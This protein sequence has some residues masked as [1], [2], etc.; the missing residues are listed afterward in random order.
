MNRF[1]SSCCPRRWAGLLVIAGLAAGLA[2]VATPVRAA[3]ADGGA[4]TLAGVTFTGTDGFVHSTCGETGG[5]GSASYEVEGRVV[6]GAWDGARFGETGT[7]SY[8]F[9]GKLGNVTAMSSEF[10]VT[11]PAGVVTG[12]RSF[13]TSGRRV[14]RALHVQPAHRRLRR[15]RCPSPRVAATPLRSRC[16][17]VGA[18][19]CRGVTGFNLGTGWEDV[20]E[21]DSSFLDDGVPTCATGEPPKPNASSPTGC[22]TA[23]GSTSTTTTSPT[24][25][26]P[27]A[28]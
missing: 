2:V 7:V 4:P 28:R 14:A 11:H 19:R 3:A 5:L 16:T 18:A 9:F 10:V 1:E 13:D 6:G 25:S 23:T 27:S 21:F 22:T 20:A 8:A 17:T 15:R 12:T 26:T 24:R